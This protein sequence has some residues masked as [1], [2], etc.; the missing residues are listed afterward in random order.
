MQDLIAVLAQGKAGIAASADLKTLE[1]IRVEFLGKSGH[2]TQLLKSLGALPAAERPK[3]GQAVNDAK[4]EL[5]ALIQQQ[6]LLQQQPTDFT[7][8]PPFIRCTPKP[9]CT[10]TTN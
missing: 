6:K 10:T 1:A 2:L 4:E 3:A 7:Q 9:P 8:R 5:L